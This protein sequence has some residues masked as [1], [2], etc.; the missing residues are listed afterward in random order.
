MEKIIL[1]IDNKR[2]LKGVK[3]EYGF[4]IFLNEKITLKIPELNEEI[5]QEISEISENLLAH[6]SFYIDTKVTLTFKLLKFI[7][8]N[9]GFTKKDK[10]FKMFYFKTNESKKVDHLYLISYYEK[11]VTKLEIDAIKQFLQKSTIVEKTTFAKFNTEFYFAFKP[12][13]TF[14]NIVYLN[15]FKNENKK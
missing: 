13:Q 12:S 3:N 7:L 2:E 4:L 15:I 10:F 6:I 8:N 5:K 1:K 14:G 11:N 9:F